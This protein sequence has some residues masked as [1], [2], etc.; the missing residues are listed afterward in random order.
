MIRQSQRWLGFFFMIGLLPL[1]AAFGQE[2]LWNIE[3]GFRWRPLPPPNAGK[4]QFS[5]V[6]GNESG[7][8]FT[9][10]LS[11]LSIAR[12]R[13]L[14]NGSGV[15]VGDFDRD[16]L[17]DL[18]ICGLETRSA[19]FR[20]LGNWRFQDVT[21]ES[22]LPTEPANSSGAVFV[23]VNGDGFLDLL[24]SSITRGIRAFLNDGGKKFL[25]TP[26]GIESNLGGTTLTLAD[27]DG[28][29]TLDL[30]AANYRTN[31]IRDRG[32][33][34]LRSVGGKPVI[35]PMFQG[36]LLI[37]E[38]K[39]AEY[40]LADQLFL[41]DGKGRF[42]P[43][44]WTEGAFLDAGGKPLKSAPL[45]WGLT[46]TF[47]DV[48][49][50][51]A[52]DLY[53]CNDYWTPDR[54]W[55]NDGKGHFREAPPL[56]LRKIP[57]S[58]MG[59]DFGDINRDG[60]LDFI[61]VEMLGNDSSSRK[62]QLMA[63]L[64][65]LPSIGLNADLPQVFH[66][67]LYFARGDGTYS[68][69]AC[70]S[71]VEA[72]DWSWSPLF[73]D[74]DLD[75]F[76]DLLISA[77]HFRDVQDMDAQRV[78]RARQHSWA[79]YTNETVRQEAFTKELMENYRL[80][81]L[82][83]LPVR[84]FRNLGNLRFQNVTTSWG[85]TNLAVH[86]GIA[87]ADFDGD[88]DLDVAVNCLNSAFEIYR[89]NAQAGRIAIRFKGLAPNTQAIGARLVFK[90]ETGLQQKEITAGGAYLS[91]S[92]ALAVFAL[93]SGRQGT[94]EIDWRSGRKTVL[95]GLMANRLY[96]I[97]EPESGELAGK[98]KQESKPLFEDFSH[99]LNHVHREIAFDDYQRQPSLPFKLSQQGPGAAWFDFDGD[100]FEDLIVGS[101]AGGSPTV[102]KADGKGKFKPGEP[103]G[104][105]V[106]NGDYL[107]IIGSPKGKGGADILAALSGYEFAQR[108]PL[109][110]LGV[111]VHPI[112]LPTNYQTATVLALG[113][114]AP[115]GEMALFIAGGVAPGRYPNGAPSA[116][117]RRDESG[118]WRFDAKNS[119]SLAGVGLVNGAVWSDLDQDGV[120]ELILACEWGPI[121]VFAIRNGLLTE[122]TDRLGLGNA[123]GLW[124][125]VATADIDGDGQM[126]IIA[127]NWGL[128]SPWKTTS[129]R[130]FTAYFGEISEPGRVEF[131]DTEWDLKS[132][133]R[134]VRRSFEGI[135][136][137][138]PFVAERVSSFK[139][140]SE[141]TVDSLLGER[142]PLSRQLSVK[143]L[144]SAVFVNRG[145]SFQPVE[146]PAEAQFAPAFSVNPADFDG[147]GNV[148]LFVSQNLM[149]MHPDFSRGDA[150]R[151]ILLRGDGKGAFEPLS[152]ER[153][154]LKIYGEQR[155]AAVCDFDHDG[156]MDVAVTQNGAETKL[157]RNTRAAPGLRVKLVGPSSN[158]TAI[159]AQIWFEGKSGRGPS[160]EVQAGSG[161]L[162][163]DAAVKVISVHEDGVVVVRWPGGA[164]SSK[165]V[166][167]Q[168]RELLITISGAE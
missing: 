147:D 10:S 154:G 9:N 69:I 153:S 53:V 134:T 106:A 81:P 49:G 101:G 68:E 33:V 135:I 83:K 157:Y 165:P 4:T 45:D 82:L 79:G 23:D 72:S 18:F 63:D 6:P 122:I 80:Y 150:G 105:V 127:A 139:E 84:A 5:P 117:I 8:L 44:S 87:L 30:Y 40:G 27:V 110:A 159:G 148:D 93:K 43:V 129:G 29:G 163:Q 62:R 137:S 38:G 60:H 25:E 14:A 118:E 124:R 56:T 36:R 32:R 2:S 109:V 145:N 102:F 149:A 74:A 73:L 7:V 119:A 144:A 78:I 161:Y 66:N 123:T 58:S 11:E 28:N 1:R 91:A 34:T 113:L 120:S 98:P 136:S 152:G 19:L 141:A 85:F 131:L 12:N 15:A 94:L 3:A 100:G 108:N 95:S 143:M 31:D 103:L 70:F 61:V 54:F 162:A 41:N 89:N 50:D 48:N 107:G 156:R 52:P 35:P 65:S 164:V 47:R 92:E 167:P 24:I 112:N 125:G 46:A 104:G 138:L 51:G 57:S 140:F 20:N 42:S 21:V 151:G 55:I 114:F 59:V 168:I 71:G 90:D 99:L 97:S 121:R 126:D 155:A 96:E 160:A 67:T 76:D 39:V 13:V 37:R 88:G 146:L 26:V 22:G 75:G 116:L 133:A 132:E 17:P 130:P 166:T 16:G 142:K 77:G 158:P 128:N 86:H 111:S 64:P 115:P